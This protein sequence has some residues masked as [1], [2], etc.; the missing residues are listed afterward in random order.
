MQTI[1]KWSFSLH[2]EDSLRLA[3]GSVNDDRSPLTADRCLDV[4]CQSPGHRLPKLN[5]KN[6]QDIDYP[7][8][9]FSDIQSVRQQ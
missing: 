4:N 6:A 7:K 5:G 9:S 3:A 8:Q 2:F 1:K